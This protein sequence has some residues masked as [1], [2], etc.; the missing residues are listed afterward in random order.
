MMLFSFIGKTDTTET[1]GVHGASVVLEN[2][3][4]EPALKLGLFNA[5]F[6]LLI[7]SL[8]CDDAILLG[9]S[10]PNVFVVRA[11][12]KKTFRLASIYAEEGSEWISTTAIH[13]LEATSS[14]NLKILPVGRMHKQTSHMVARL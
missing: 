6:P 14:Y 2:K 10:N 7:L 1:A 11:R 9:R 5:S 8:D 4:A 13:F 12:T 3:W